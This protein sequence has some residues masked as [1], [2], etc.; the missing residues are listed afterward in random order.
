VKG[1]WERLPKIKSGMGLQKRNRCGQT[2]TTAFQGTIVIEGGKKE[3]HVPGSSHWEKYEHQVRG[4]D[5]HLQES[6]QAF[7][8]KEGKVLQS[9][10]YHRHKRQVEIIAIDGSQWVFFSLRIPGFY[11]ES[12]CYLPVFKY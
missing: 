1:E 7:L 6:Q 4:E 5:T 8:Q 9:M 10:M 11:R 12:Q 2:K 3:T